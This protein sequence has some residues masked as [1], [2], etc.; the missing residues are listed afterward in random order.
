C[1]RI[2]LGE[3]YVFAQAAPAW[4]LAPTSIVLSPSS[5]C[6]EP[7]CAASGGCPTVRTWPGLPPL[8]ECGVS[9]LADRSCS[10]ATPHASCVAASVITLAVAS[11]PFFQR[12][13]IMWNDRCLNRQDAIVLSRTAEQLM[14]LA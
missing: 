7:L 3:L 5:S 6:P 14:R 11:H 2:T 4:R 8:G 9:R 12:N 1:L 10:R 13:Q